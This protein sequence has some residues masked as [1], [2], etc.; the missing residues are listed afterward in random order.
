MPRGDR[1]GPFGEGPKTGRQ[2][3][4]CTGHDSPGFVNVRSAW[5]RGPGRGFGRGFG[6]GF[7]RGTGGGFGRGFRAGPG[8]GYGRF[9]EEI[10]EISEKTLIE[11]EIRILKDQLASLEDRLSKLGEE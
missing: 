9:Y 3:G 5:A 11:N 2:M 1:T 6:W 10:P 4:Y 7:G 8:Y